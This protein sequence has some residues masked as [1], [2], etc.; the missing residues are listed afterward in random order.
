MQ[1][2]DATDE[3]GAVTSAPKQPKPALVRSRTKASDVLSIT[4]TLVAEPC[5]DVEHA[6][7][8]NDPRAWSNAR[9]TFT[10]ILISVASMIATI[11]STIQNPVAEQI[12]AD[13]SATGSQFS[14]DISTFILI[15]GLVPLIWNTIYEMKGSKFVYVFSLV[16]FTIANIFLA[17]SRHF[18]A[19]I[20]LRGLQAA[21]SS[22]VMAIG[23]ASIADIFELEERGQKMGIYNVALLL[24]PALGPIFGGSLASIWN[25]RAIFWFLTLVLGMMLLAFAF[26]FRDTF[27]RE[28]SL[29]FQNM[30]KQRIKNLLQTPS[31]KWKSSIPDD[32]PEYKS[33]TIVDIEKTFAT[34]ASPQSGDPSHP[35]SSQIRLVTTN[36]ILL[37]PL[38]LVV[39]RKANLLVLLSSGLFFAYGFLIHYATAR[40]LSES[41]NYDPIKIGLVITLSY[42]TGCVLGGILGGRLSDRE[43][44]RLTLVN[45]G[46]SYPEMRLKSTIICACLFPMIVVGFGWLSQKSA[47][48][49]VI[50]VK[51][52]LGGFLNNWLFSIIMAY[53]IDANPGRSSTAAVAASAFRGVLAFTAAETAVPLQ[54]NLGNGWLFTIWSGILSLAGVC[55]LIVWLKGAQW[56][57]QYESPAAKENEIGITLPSTPKTGSTFA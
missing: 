57:G 7:V 5:Y 37:K 3:Q 50:V 17:L 51:L 44:R 4:P 47:H 52:F 56:R 33:G 45:G 30:L 21:G 22:A 39:Q 12:E 20:G 48:I 28:R 55:T 19:V 42:G 27:R 14:L 46:Q 8:D 13:L 18:G 25:W 23:P 49:S 1:Y 24:G 53:I 2:S 35:C 40:T 11:C 6:P 16:L 32:G 54:D 10:L 36:A 38:L 43:L 9:K 15:Q 29:T 41:F 26:F 34:Q 31:P